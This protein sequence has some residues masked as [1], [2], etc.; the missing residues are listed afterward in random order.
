MSGLANLS[1]LQAELAGLGRT[2]TTSSSYSTA[3]LAGQDAVLLFGY[4]QGANDATHLA[5]YVNGGANFHDA[6]QRPGAWKTSTLTA[7]LTWHAQPCRASHSIS[8]SI[9]G[10][11][12]WA[13]ACTTI[14]A[15]AYTLPLAP[16]T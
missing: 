6:G 11:P 15:T 2:V 8:A 5:A 16:R 10:R 3:L 1:L 9:A 7:A 4:G 14:T 13:S 12:R